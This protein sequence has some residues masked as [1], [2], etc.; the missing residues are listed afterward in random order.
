MRNI[1]VYCSS[2]SVI[3]PTYF[4]VA[5]ELGARIAARG[6]ALVYGGADLGLMGSVARAV[7]EGEEHLDVPVLDLAFLEGGGP[8][9]I[10]Y[11][12]DGVIA[13]TRGWE[14]INSD[15]GNTAAIRAGAL[16]YLLKDS[17]PLALIDAIY[18]VHRG[19]PSLD[20]TVALKVMRELGRPP[21]LPPAEEP[22]MPG[23][24]RILTET[25][26]AG[27]P[28]GPTTTPSIVCAS[29][30]RRVKRSVPASTSVSRRGG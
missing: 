21:D 15:N 25:P 11:N 2:S 13:T 5:R 1:C 18:D 26:G 14:T 20:P 6:D 12:E 22:L 19:E 29:E 24:G 7:H 3:A 4:D 8:A 16:G 27:V 30:S 10:H 23:M 9:G 17:P 28:S